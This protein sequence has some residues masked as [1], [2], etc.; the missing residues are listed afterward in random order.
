MREE[1]MIK[2]LTDLAAEMRTQSI[3]YTSGLIAAWADTIDIIIRDLEEK[4]DK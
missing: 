1:D 3:I 2:T 4:F